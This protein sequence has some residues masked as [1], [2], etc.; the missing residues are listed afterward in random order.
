MERFKFRRR[1]SNVER[2]N[3]AKKLLESVTFPLLVNRLQEEIAYYDLESKL[4]DLF[5]NHPN[6]EVVNKES[7]RGGVYYSLDINLISRNIKDG[8]YIVK[9]SRI[10]CSLVRENY[11]ESWR[12]IGADYHWISVVSSHGS[13]DYWH[14]DKLSF[15]ISQLENQ[16]KL[17][18]MCEELNLMSKNY[19]PI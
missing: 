9:P 19:F 10:T 5:V 7:A 15:L 1:K 14:K 8:E 17:E 13:I 4:I 18:K 12:N 6:L 3:R 11:L 2:Y 16:D